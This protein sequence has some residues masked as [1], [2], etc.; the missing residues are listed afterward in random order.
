MSQKE[1]FE[2]T[3]RALAD[4][5]NCQLELDRNEFTLTLKANQAIS[6]FEVLRDKP[7]LQFDQL[8]DVAGIDYLE[9]G[10]TEWKTKQATGSGFSR[11]VTKNTFGRFTFDDNPIDNE[12]Q[13]VENNHRLRVKIF[14]EDNEMPMVD[15]VCSIWSCANWYEREAF[16]MYG[17]VFD[18]HPDMRRL[19]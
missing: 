11:G 6:V 15:S 16:D 17:I 14:C 8:M 9:H 19:L 7:A 1:L 4:S 3:L 13:S 10:K 5:E 12:M 2:S 18:G